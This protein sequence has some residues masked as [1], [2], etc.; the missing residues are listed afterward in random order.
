MTFENGVST[1]TLKHNEK[2]TATGL[3]AGI[4]YEVTES[5]ANQD[6]YTTTA[7]GVK[8]DIVKDETATAAF[9]NTKNNGGDDSGYG[10]L[11][12]SKTVSGTAGDTTKAFTFTIKLDCSISGK[13]G[14]MTFDKGIATIKLKH[15]ESSTAKGLPSGTHYSVTESDN[16]GYIVNAIGSDG[17]IDEGKTVVAAFTNKKDTTPVTPD[18]PKVPDKPAVQTNSAPQTGDDSNVGFYLALMIISFTAFTGIGIFRRKR[19]STGR[20]VQK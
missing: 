15:G 20:H 8:G 14:D 1:F 7:T 19:S 5:E 3:P 10:N 13:Y 11:T 18:N 9:T 12:V 17:I 16:E 6:G 2:K 4:S